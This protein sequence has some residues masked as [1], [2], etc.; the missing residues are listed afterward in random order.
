MVDKSITDLTDPIT[1]SSLDVYPGVYQDVREDPNT[2]RFLA[3]Y[4]L[5]P[6]CM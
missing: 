4:F 1:G 6:A 3:A 5:S 2:L